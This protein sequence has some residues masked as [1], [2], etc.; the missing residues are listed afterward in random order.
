VRLWDAATGKEVLKLEPGAGR[1][2]A[3]AFSPDGRVLATAG[4]DDRAIRLWDPR[5]GTQRR[6]ERDT[7]PAAAP[8]LFEGTLGLAFSPN[9]R[10]LA[11]VSF[12]EHKSNLVPTTPA[13]AKDVRMVGLWEVATGQIRHEVR[14]PRNSVR[15]AAFLENRFLAVGD[16]DGAVRVLDLAR[17]EWL[18]PAGGH[19]DAIAALTVA[20]DGRSF[21]SGSWDTTALVWRTEQVLGRRPLAGARRP[22]AELAALADDLVGGDP[23][24]AYRAVWALAAEPGSVRLLKG[25]VWSVPA[26]DEARLRALIRDLDSDA[27]RTRE[28]ATTELERLGELAA[29][30]LREVLRGSPSAELRRRAEGLLLRLESSAATTWVRALEVLELLGTPEAERL[31]EELAAGAPAARQT[32]EASASLRRLKG[33]SGRP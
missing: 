3:L 14:L 32:Q 17:N 24:R 31:L 15:C 28:A 25:R 1:V 7:D 6:L 16:L 12:Y 11:A 30:A 20:P 8:G 13:A 27:Y 18:P 4:L 22:T 9:G 33:R 29:P 2:S 19:A 23:V 10:T 21:A 26:A 5:T